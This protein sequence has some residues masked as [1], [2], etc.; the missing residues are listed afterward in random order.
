MSSESKEIESIKPVNNSSFCRCNAVCLLIFMIKSKR[1]L[2]PDVLKEIKI[3][4][5]IFQQK[6]WIKWIRVCKFLQNRFWNRGSECAGINFVTKSKYACVHF[7][8]QINFCSTVSRITHRATIKTQSR[9]SLRVCGLSLDPKYY[10]CTIFPTWLV[11]NC[12]LSMCKGWRAHK[13][14][15]R[16]L[17]FSTCFDIIWFA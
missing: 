2:G 14:K 12:V 6:F 8:L 11:N 5:L 16:F 7:L 4:N 9:G 17:T 13:L 10:S 15:L 1:K 3:L